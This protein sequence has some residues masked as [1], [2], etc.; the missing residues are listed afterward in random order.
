MILYLKASR[1]TSRTRRSSRY[2]KAIKGP[3]VFQR[4]DVVRDG[5]DVA[6][7]GDQAPEVNGFSCRHETRCITTKAKSCSEIAATPSP[8]VPGSSM[9]RFFTSHWTISAPGIQK[10]TVI[11]SDATTTEPGIKS[12]FPLLDSTRLRPGREKGLLGASDSHTSTRRSTVRF[13][14][15]RGLIGKDIVCLQP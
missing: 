5:E 6:V 9:K 4:Q 12:T 10:S 13:I 3:V 14:R 11:H 1:H 2:L 8:T 15:G 7:G